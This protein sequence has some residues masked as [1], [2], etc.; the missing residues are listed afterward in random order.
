M[1]ESKNKDFV[2]FYSKV[3]RIWKSSKETPPEV[4]VHL[5]VKQCITGEFIGAGIENAEEFLSKPTGLLS[6]PR[7]AGH[8]IFLDF[9][10]EVQIVC[11]FLRSILP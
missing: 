6:V 4:T 10:K 9:G 8:Y 7:I 3:D 1:E 2:F 11:H 5:L